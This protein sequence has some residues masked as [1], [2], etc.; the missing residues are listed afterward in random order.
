MPTH[1]PSQGGLTP[2]L[3][4]DRTSLLAE[5]QAIIDQHG[6][7][8]SHNLA[9][10]Y[11]VF[12]MGEQPRGDNFRSSK[13]LQLARDVLRKPFTE[14]RVLDLGCGEGLYAVEFAQQGASVLAVEGRTVNL[15]KAEFAGRALSLSRLEVR[16]GDVLEVN[17]ERDGV[18]DVVLCSGILYHLDQPEVFH[19][20]RNL[21]AMCTG[22]CIIDTRVSLTS[23]VEAEYE[24][25]SYWGKLYR[26]HAP[27][28]SEEEKLQQLG[29]S[30][31]NDVSFWF[32]RASLANLLGDLGYSTVM[33]CWIPTPY[34]IRADRTTFVAV[35]GSRARAFHE[36]GSGLHELR[37][38][39]SEDAEPGLGGSGS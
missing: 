26:E 14:L 5:R 1:N 29:A 22:V 10:P 34:T 7:W 2:G 11:G 4:T 19:F 33:E 20:L 6:P 12:T 21:R 3:P 8:A 18:F 16:Q 17:R 9:L 27:G 30:L 28:S 23:E 32:T 35:P 15:V 31:N 37:W 24:G 38:P 25:R 36:I 39:E 13:F